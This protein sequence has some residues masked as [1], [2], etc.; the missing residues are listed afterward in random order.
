MK[1]RFIY[2]FVYFLSGCTT[3]E[4]GIAVHPDAWDKPESDLKSPLGY[5]RLSHDF[6]N[7]V[8]LSFEHVSGIFE[9][10][11]GFG[12]NMIQFGVKK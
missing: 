12:L 9:T 8:S 1:M 6:D 5:V 3:I 7:G 2:L 4:A 11:Q 10:E